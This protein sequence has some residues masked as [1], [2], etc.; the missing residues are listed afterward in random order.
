MKQKFGVENW[1]FVKSDDVALKRVKGKRS[2]Q[3]EAQL[4]VM[5]GCFSGTSRKKKNRLRG[6]LVLKKNIYEQFEIFEKSW[7]KRWKELDVLWLHS[8]QVWN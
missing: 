1:A 2:V 7:E 4:L 8:Q 3:F 5:Q 6:F